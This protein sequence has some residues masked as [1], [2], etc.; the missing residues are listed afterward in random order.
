MCKRLRRLFS[1][2]EGGYN[3]LGVSGIIMF[4]LLVLLVANMAFFYM[5]SLQYETNR[6]QLMS[7]ANSYVD[8]ITENRKITGAMHRYYCNNLKKIDYYVKDYTVTYKIYDVDKSTGDVTKKE[9]HSYGLDDSIG[10]FILNKGQIVRVEI[11]SPSDT[12]LAR[13]S[14]L[15]SIGK[16]DVDAAVIGYAEGGVN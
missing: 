2:R 15:L 14:K 16:D 4:V 10:D 9:E 7:E 1:K 13:F 12:P 3:G 8:V 5:I 11:A 6:F